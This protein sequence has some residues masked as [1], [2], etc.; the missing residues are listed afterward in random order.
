M[1]NKPKPLNGPALANVWFHCKCSYSR[2]KAEFYCTRCHSWSVTESDGRLGP[3]ASE[4]IEEK[5]ND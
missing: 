1:T 2:C 3:Y 4:F 5:D